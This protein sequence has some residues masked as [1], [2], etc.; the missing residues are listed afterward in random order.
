MTQPFSKAHCTTYAAAGNSS[1]QCKPSTQPSL[2]PYKPAITRQDLDMQLL[3]LLLFLL[4][5]LLLL[6]CNATTR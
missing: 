2:R 1:M 4:L 5:L 3:L 6:L